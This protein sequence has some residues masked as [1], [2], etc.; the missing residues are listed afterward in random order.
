V[1]AELA[2]HLGLELDY[3]GI[4]AIQKEAAVVYPELIGMVQEVATGGGAQP[5][6]LGAARP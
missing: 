6:L 4:F 1:L 3:P 2:G 5:V